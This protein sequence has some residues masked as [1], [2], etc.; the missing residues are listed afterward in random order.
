MYNNIYIVFPVQFF[1]VHFADF[2]FSTSLVLF[3]KLYI[4]D[5]MNDF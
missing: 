5:T 3:F 2:N 1:N 4:A